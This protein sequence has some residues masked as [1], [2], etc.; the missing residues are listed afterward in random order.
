MFEPI[1]NANKWDHNWL[2][3]V[4]GERMTVA[5]RATVTGADFDVVYHPVGYVE[6]GRFIQPVYKDG[7]YK[8]EPRD[9]YIVRADN[10]A[11]LGVHS[12]KYPEREGYSHVFNTL[13]ELFPNACSNITVFGEGERVV[14]EQELDEPISIGDGDEIQPYLYTR[15]S[16]NG[17]WKTETIPMHKRLMCENMLGHTGQLFGVRATSR[18]DQLLSMRAKVV[19]LAIAQ[20]ETLVRMAQILSDKEFADEE[21]KRMVDEIMPYPTPVNGEPVHTN[22]LDAVLKKRSALFSGWGAESLD[23]GNNMWAAYNAVQG[24]EQHRINKGYKDTPASNQRSINR[25]LEGKTPIADAASEY[26]AK[27]AVDDPFITR[28]LNSKTV[29]MDTL[30]RIG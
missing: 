18:H 24:A 4:E 13:E 26:L 1:N 11:V 29:W 21:F 3:N 10:G 8:G 2:V 14:V 30:L 17:S 22:T 27:V 5:E 16:L 7:K 20:G 15:M 23:V 9:R 6:D 25:A 19:D 12:G 28:D